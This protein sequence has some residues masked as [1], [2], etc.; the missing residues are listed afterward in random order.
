MLDP[1]IIEEI[2]RREEEQRRRD[3]RPQLDVP[4]EDEEWRPHPEADEDEPE[5]E[6]EKKDD[7]NRRG[8]VIIDYAV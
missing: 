1:W 6:G 3:E 2:R 7:E 8:V 4:L 5:G